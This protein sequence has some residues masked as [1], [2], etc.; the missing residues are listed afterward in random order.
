MEA[1][2]L[3]R[4]CTMA[5]KTARE[6]KDYYV[7]GHRRVPKDTPTAW[8]SQVQSEVRAPCGVCVR[9]GGGREGRERP[10][11]S[12]HFLLAGDLFFS[13]RAGGGHAL[14]PTYCS[15]EV[16]CLLNKYHT[17]TRRGFVQLRRQNERRITRER[18]NRTE[19][20]RTE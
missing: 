7:F 14:T 3:L 20:N 10:C 12:T 16:V 1:L 19:S 17:S 13:P 18:E 11:C 6:E 4:Q 15:H 2:S 5:R 9:E 8:K